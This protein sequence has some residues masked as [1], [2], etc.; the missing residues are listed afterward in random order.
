MNHCYCDQHNQFH[1]RLLTSSM[2]PCLLT[3]GALTTTRLRHLT[4]LG[5]G[6]KEHQAADEGKLPI[7]SI[8]K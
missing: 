8:K 1:P 6:V 2:Q 5:G 7:N 4:G 3:V